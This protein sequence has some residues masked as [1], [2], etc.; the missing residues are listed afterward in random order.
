MAQRD[1]GLLGSF[2]DRLIDLLRLYM[3]VGGMPEPVLRHPEGASAEAVRSIQA[4]ILRRY[5]SDFAKYPSAVQS[6]QTAQLWA[7]MP[8]QLA[9]ENKRFLFGHREQQDMTNVPLY[10]I[11]PWLR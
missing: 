2:H 6:R 4:D 5:E 10:A 11:G 9:R 8:A 1:W 7:S 3:F